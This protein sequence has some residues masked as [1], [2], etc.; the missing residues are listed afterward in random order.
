MAGVLMAQ[1]NSVRNLIK[2][3]AA[4]SGKRLRRPRHS[5]SEFK[6]SNASRRFRTEVLS[7]LAVAEAKFVTLTV[8]KEGR[9]IMDTPDHYAYLVC[10]LLEQCWTEYPNVQLSLDRHFTSP[11]QVA[12][13]NTLLYRR[14]PRQGILSVVHVDSRH[15]PLVGLADFVAGSLYSWRKR[16]DETFRLIEP[17][18]IASR[19]EGWTR[20][21]QKWLGDEK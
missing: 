20:I 18:V 16:G 7:A 12:A 11:T 13:T 19:D 5:P 17:K 8:R 3:V 2:R 10:E 6:W 21:K 9:V 1:P 4:R 15:S 14:W